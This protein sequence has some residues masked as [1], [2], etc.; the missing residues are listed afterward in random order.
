MTDGSEMK[1]FG[2]RGARFDQRSTVPKL[3]SAS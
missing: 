3:V 1:I 2:A